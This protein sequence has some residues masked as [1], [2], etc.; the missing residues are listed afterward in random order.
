MKNRT[1]AGRFTDDN[2]VKTNHTRCL[3]LYGLIYETEQSVG[4]AENNMKAVGVD[5]N[6]MKAVGVAENI[7]KAVGVTTIHNGS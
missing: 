7:M 6:N 5:E 3:C 2:E 4:V 1:T